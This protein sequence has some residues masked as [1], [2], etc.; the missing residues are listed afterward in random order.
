MNANTV[1][2]DLIAQIGIIV[3]DVEK[4]SAAFAKIF[5]METPAWSWTGEYS[6]AQTQYRGKPTPARSKLAFFHFGQVDIEFI[7]PDEHP[8]TW[9]E[10]LDSKGE[11]VHHIAFIIDGMAARTAALDAAGIPLVQKG[12]Y[13]GGRYAY[14][15]S[16]EP[17]KV[18][19][20]L[21]ENDKR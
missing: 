21:L 1:G 14:F 12:E 6:R 4:T 7:E 17:L 10:F 15:D 9:R 11:G 19:L 13:T 16:F 20:E 5:G 2:S 8:S 18:I 3:R